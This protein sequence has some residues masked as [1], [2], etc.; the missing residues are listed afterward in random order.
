MDVSL[1]ICSVSFKSAHYLT[2]NWELTRQLNTGADFWKWM[3]IENTPEGAIGKLSLDDSKFVIM[4][5]M[6]VPKNITG[7][8]SY[9]HAAALNKVI[10]YVKTRFLLI[11]DPDFFIV[12]KNWINEVTGHM[13]KNDLGF[14][15]A[16][17]HPRWYRKYRYFPCVHC[18]FIDLN[19]ISLTDIDFMP[20]LF[21]SFVSKLWARNEQLLDQKQR[22]RACWT[23][24][25]HP[26]RALSEDI[27]QRQLIGTSRDTG[28]SLFQKYAKHSQVKYESIKAVFRPEIDRFKPSGVSSLQRSRLVELILPDRLSYI[29]KRKDYFARTGFLELGYADLSSLEWEEFIWRDQPFGFH[30][31]GFLQLVHDVERN[32][33]MLFQVLERLTDLKFQGQSPSRQAQR[34]T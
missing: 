24:M 17:W 5:G 4:P 3:V 20:D 30:I 8:A 34:A 9:H 15:G 11:L 25:K 7:R 1:T 23:V 32:D 33:A 12:R 27:K 6:D 26:K 31:R 14:F 10:S 18:M 16:P 28:Y 13:I 29:P 21:K 2:L 22:V 19:R